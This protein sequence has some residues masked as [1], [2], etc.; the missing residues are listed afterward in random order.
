M[1]NPCNLYGMEIKIL[2]WPIAFLFCGSIHS[3]TAHEWMRQ[4][5]KDYLNNN[6]ESAAQKYTNAAAQEEDGRAYYNLGNAL[7]AQGKYEDAYA[8][9]QKSL[10]TAENDNLQ[11]KNWHNSGNTLARQ[12]KYK[13]AVEA[14]K[15]A[16]KLKPEDVATKQNLM[17]A[18]RQMPPPQ[19][20]QQKKQQKEKDASED[21]DQK[22][23]PQN[24][25]GEQKDQAPKEQEQ[26]RQQ[27]KEIN[28]QE[29]ERLLKAVQKEDEEVQKKVKKKKAEPG[30]RPIKDW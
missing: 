2:V 6:F 15:N 21:Q 11:F 30:N 28:K 22:K 12:Q 7:Y 16:L 17:R 1:F 14:Y 13:E 9:Y 29:A 19:Q 24:Q 3:Q 10:E 4:G 27:P 20:Q 5:E 8:A 26:Q 25:E 18:L 23:Q